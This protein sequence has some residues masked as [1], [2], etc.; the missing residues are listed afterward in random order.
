MIFE[1]EKYYK[2]IQQLERYQSIVY[3]IVMIIAV[4]TGIAGGG[5]AL[6]ITIPVGMLIS[7]FYLIATRVKIQEMKWKFDIYN[8]LME[9]K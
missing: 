6:I 4:I 3:A 2:Y 7:W 1:K 9:Q 8:K 5:I